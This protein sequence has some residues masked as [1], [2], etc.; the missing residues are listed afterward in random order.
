[1]ERKEFLVLH[2][3]AESS[4]FDAPR[5][6]TFFIKRIKLCISEGFQAH[7][8]LPLISKRY[9]SAIKKKKKKKLQKSR[10]IIKRYRY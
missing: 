7:S 6:E 2:F 3:I 5:I 10:N 1:M 9:S 8:A 4:R